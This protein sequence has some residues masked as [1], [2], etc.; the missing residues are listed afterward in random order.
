MPGHDPI[1]SLQRLQAIGRIRGQ[2]GDGVTPGYELLL[3]DFDGTLVDTVEDIAFYAN[4]VLSGLGFASCPIEQVKGAIGSGVH[5]L[6]KSLAPELAGDPDTLEEAVQLFKRRYREQ[7]IRKTKSFPGV[8]DMLSGPLSKVKKTIITNKPQDI[9]LQILESLNLKIYFD[10]VIGMHAGY[11]PKPDPESALFTIRQF[12][13]DPRRCIYVGDSRVDAETSKN[14]GVD[15]AWVRYGYDRLGTEKRAY[16]FD[17]AG[18]W[19]ALVRS[20]GSAPRTR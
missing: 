10:L 12:G 20:E 7:P 15:F 14:A 16:E 17:N 8:V 5:E 3:F 19:E 2:R 6:L 1:P 4:A 13:A 18:E 11:P 9:T